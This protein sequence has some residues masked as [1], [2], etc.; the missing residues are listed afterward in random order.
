ML[1]SIQE[2]LV[3]RVPHRIDAFTAPHLSKDF[4]LKIEQGRQ[5]IL[6]FSLTRTIDPN[7]A[8]VVLQGLMLAKQRNAQFSLK[9]VQPQV[10]VILEMAGVLRFFRKK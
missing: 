5:I 6:D 1:N 8:D 9:N 7:A 3:I 10:R 4:E 2:K